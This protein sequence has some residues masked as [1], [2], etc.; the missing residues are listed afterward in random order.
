M[1]RLN[2]FPTREEKKKRCAIV[3]SRLYEAT[4]KIYF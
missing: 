2:R 1:D 4:G 3:R